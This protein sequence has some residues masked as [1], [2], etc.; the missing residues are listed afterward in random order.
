MRKKSAL[1][2]SA[3]DIDVLDES[4]IAA[5]PFLSRLGLDVLDSKTNPKK[6]K[7]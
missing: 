3:S 6:V 1:L 7:S 5:H 4:A 2:Y